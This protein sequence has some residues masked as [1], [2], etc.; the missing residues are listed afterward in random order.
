MNMSSYCPMS[1]Q[2]GVSSLMAASR[3]GHVEV[4][5]KLVQHEATVDLASKVRSIYF[6][7]RMGERCFSVLT[8]QPFVFNTQY[9]PGSLLKMLP[10]LSCD[11]V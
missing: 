11:I 3:N 7:L 6:C 1:S 2:D 4:V 5:E 8:I 9:S 10:V